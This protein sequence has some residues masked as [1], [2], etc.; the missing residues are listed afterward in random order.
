MHP[1][2]PD[3]WSDGIQLGDGGRPGTIAL[4]GVGQLSRQV[5]EN[6]AIAP[7]IV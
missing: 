1:S 6:T 5:H 4:A 3:A 2:R 7:C